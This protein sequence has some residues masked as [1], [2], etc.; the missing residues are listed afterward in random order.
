V[1][2]IRPAPILGTVFS[3]GNRLLAEHAAYL[4]VDQGAARI[5]DLE[6]GEI[7]QTVLIQADEVVR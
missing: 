1:E 3:V 5:A 6:L 2:L 7:P 4:A